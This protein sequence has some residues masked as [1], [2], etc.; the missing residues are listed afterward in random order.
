[1]AIHKIRDIERTRLP[2]GVRVVTEVMPHVRSVSVGVWIGTGS[3]EE[4]PHETGLSHFIE[5]MVFKG[6]KNRTA[7]QI[8][9]SVDSIGGG[10]DAFTSKEL[11][12]YNVKVLDEHLPEAFDVVAD[13]VRNPLFEPKD[14]EKEKGV[15]LEE[16][17]MEVDNPEYLLHEIFSSN[18][19]KGHALGRPILGT[20]QTI[21]SFNR[22]AVER[23]YREFYTPSN[24][25]IT[26]AGN[27]KHKHLLRLSEDRFADWKRS[28][29]R[30]PKKPPRPHAPLIFRNKNSLEQVHVY[31]GVPSVPMTH[32]SRFAAYIL[33]AILGGGMSS[34]LF[35]NIREKQGLAYAVYSELAMYRDAGCMLVY[36]GTSLRSAGK[37]IDSVV[38]EL[39][40]VMEHPVSPEE[41]RRAKDHIKGSFVLGLESTSSRMGNLARQELYFKRFFSLDEMLERIERVNAEEVRKLA[42]QF[43]DPR[44]MAVTMLGRLEGFRVRRQDLIH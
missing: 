3:R 5:H 1:M 33:N 29:V 13:L 28:H 42:E 39:R 22:D 34:R 44:K 4:E 11:V 41:L 32:E 8:A 31:L 17:K 7:E 12:S 6:T 14:I 43:F 15:I 35:Q 2:N 26:A 10:L 36:A 25:L 19:W 24:V 27:L 23:Y 30:S 18:F 37:V 9:R 38:R 20:K 40:E 21:R 16:L